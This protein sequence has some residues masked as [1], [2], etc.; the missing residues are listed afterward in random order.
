MPTKS[1][2][3]SVKAFVVLRAPRSGDEAMMKALR[4][5]VKATVAPYEYPLAVECREALPRTKTEKLQRF[6]F[7]CEPSACCISLS[8][9]NCVGKWSD[10]FRLAAAGHIWPLSGGCGR[11]L[12]FNVPEDV[13]PLYLGTCRSSRFGR[14]PHD[15]GIRQAAASK[16]GEGGLPT[17]CSRLRNNEVVAVELREAFQFNLQACGHGAR[18][19]CL[20]HRCSL[21]RLFAIQRHE[22]S[23]QL[24]S[25]E[26]WVRALGTAGPAG[27]VCFDHAG[28]RQSWLDVPAPE[29]LRDLA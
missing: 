4:D 2:A 26:N 27:C 15:A 12:S 1:A 17:L 22:T 19:T 10:H 21:S 28:F 16:G 29:Q 9:S 5:F 18:E 23:N 14:C 13:R 8:S 20:R 11:N 6:R 25:T 7:A 3:R 24:R